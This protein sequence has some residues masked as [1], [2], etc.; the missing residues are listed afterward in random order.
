[1]T[2]TYILIGVGLLNALLL[3]A[4]VGMQVLTLRNITIIEKATNSMK[5]ALIE[6]ASREGITEGKRQAAEDKSE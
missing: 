4:L 1:M 5:D 2:A 6:S 3:M